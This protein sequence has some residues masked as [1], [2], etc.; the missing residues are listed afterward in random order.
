MLSPSNQL[1]PSKVA[2]DFS[3]ASPILMIKEQ[4]LPRAFLFPHL[5]IAIS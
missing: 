5:Q 4:S 3:S 2:I 1:F